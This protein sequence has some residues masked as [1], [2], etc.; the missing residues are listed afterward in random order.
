MSTSTSIHSVTRI[1][2]TINHF[3]HGGK[4]S[5]T[6]MNLEVFGKVFI[7]GVHH[8][9]E[10]ATLEFFFDSEEEFNEVVEPLCHML[11]GRLM[12]RMHERVEVTRMS[13]HI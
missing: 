13:E 10:L 12:P 9:V 7:K 2:P 8:E 4:S 6:T 1:N 3:E 11:V 5:F